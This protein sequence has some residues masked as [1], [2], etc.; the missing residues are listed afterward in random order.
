MTNWLGTRLHPFSRRQPQRSRVP[1]AIAS[2]AGRRR[3][4]WAKPVPSSWRRDWRPHGSGADRQ[5]IPAAARDGRG[6]VANP[7]QRAAQAVLV[8]TVPV[9]PCSGGF[10]DRVPLAEKSRI[11][12]YRPAEIS[13]TLVSLQIA[14]PRLDADWSL[15]SEQPIGVGAVVR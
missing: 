13:Y 5:R 1:T 7:P 4:P 3:Q 10:N 2:T 8:V 12:L 9:S 14:G 15:T 11:L 6:A